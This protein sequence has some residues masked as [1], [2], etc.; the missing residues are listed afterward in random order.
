VAQPMDRPTKP[1]GQPTPQS[2]PPAWPPAPPSA[3]RPPARPPTA[4]TGAAK[5]PAKP[6]TATAGA[7]RPPRRDR[8]WLIDFLLGV[9][10]GM[11]VML[12]AGTILWGF[13]ILP[14]LEVYPES[15]ACISSALPP[16]VSD[17][18]CRLPRDTRASA[19]GRHP[20]SPP[21]HRTCWRRNRGVLRLPVPIPGTRARRWRPVADDRI[22]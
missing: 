1:R 2:K 11:T 6:P 5:P 13:G 14:I 4:A 15:A 20:V 21:Q 16:A 17:L 9:L 12:A 7:A 10:F 8:G 22:R 18:R 3:Y 19:G